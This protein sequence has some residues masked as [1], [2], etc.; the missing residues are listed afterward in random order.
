MPATTPAPPPPSVFDQALLRLLPGPTRAGFTALLW[1]QAHERAQVVAANPGRVRAIPLGWLEHVLALCAPE[2]ATTALDAD[3]RVGAHDVRQLLRRWWALSTVPTR[4]EAYHASAIHDELEMLLRCDASRAAEM[5]D[6]PPVTRALQYW[7]AANTEQRRRFTY[8]LDAGVTTAMLTAR[9]VWGVDEVA[10]FSSFHPPRDS[11][12]RD[13]LAL[14]WLIAGGL[15]TLTPEAAALW[16][17]RRPGDAGTFDEETGF[18]AFGSWSPVQVAFLAAAAGASLTN[19]DLAT[20]HPGDSL[21]ALLGAVAGTRNEVPLVAALILPSVGHV[22]PSGSPPYIAHG[23]LLAAVLPKASPTARLA[24]ATRLTGTHTE[25]LQAMWDATPLDDAD[26]RAWLDE[27]TAS[28]AG[29]A[30]L[31][32]GGIEPP[33]RRYLLAHVPGALPRL[34]AAFA[35]TASGADRGVLQDLAYVLH[36]QL[37]SD[38][39][40]W[41]CAM[42]VLDEHATLAEVAQAARAIVNPLTA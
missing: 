30:A 36:D 1:P 23:E 41:R 9:Q 26:L 22:A 39:D 11:F 20:I 35:G 31:W 28:P 21:V 29:W 6:A 5:V 42:A 7:D 19:E 38:G 13:P 34:R 3:C 8:R 40:V 15:P 24:I 14:L 10:L 27:F 33:F 32:D 18:L 25:P 12:Y 16:R 37:G 17:D 2:E 4:S